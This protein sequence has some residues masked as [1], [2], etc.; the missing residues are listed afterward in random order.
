MPNAICQHFQNVFYFTLTN[1]RSH[2]LLV[3]LCMAASINMELTTALKKTARIKSIII[4]SHMLAE[5]AIAKFWVLQRKNGS[6]SLSH[7]LSLNNKLKRKFFAMLSFSL[8]SIAFQVCISYYIITIILLMLEN[9]ME[10][11]VC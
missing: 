5:F 7:H 1:V 9:R 3:F 10:T 4:V 8:D 6:S 11:H 2:F